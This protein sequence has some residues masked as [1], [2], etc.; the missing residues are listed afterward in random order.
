MLRSISRDSGL[1]GGTEDRENRLRF[2]MLYSCF[3]FLLKAASAALVSSAKRRILE[4]PRMLKTSWISG[5]VE[6]N[7]R[8]PLFFIAVSRELMKQPKPAEEMYLQCFRLTTMRQTPFEKMF[9]IAV[10]TLAK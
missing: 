5:G 8:S 7:T 6:A 1:R 4:R 2:S 3:Y 9:S 10:S